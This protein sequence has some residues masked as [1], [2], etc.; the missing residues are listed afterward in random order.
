[1]S[2][3]YAKAVGPMSSSKA[4]CSHLHLIPGVWLQG[5]SIAAPRKQATA[6]GDPPT[7]TSLAVLAATR[8]FPG[9]QM[10]GSSMTPASTVDDH[11]SQEQLLEAWEADVPLLPPGLGSAVPSCPSDSHVAASASAGSHSMP[12]SEPSAWCSLCRQRRSCRSRRPDS[13]RR[14]L[15]GA[16]CSFRCSPS[17]TEHAIATGSFLCPMGV[18]TR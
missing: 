10:T 4:A 17:S 15:S 9:D 14:E 18:A 1:M 6:I 16:S 3:P 2:L 5:R 8:G 12:L 11:A 13:S 7:A